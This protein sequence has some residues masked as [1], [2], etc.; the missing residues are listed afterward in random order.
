[1]ISYKQSK[2]ISHEELKGSQRFEIKH[3]MLYNILLDTF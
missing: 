1:M 2:N 3:K